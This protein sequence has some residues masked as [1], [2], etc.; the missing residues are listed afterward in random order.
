MIYSKDNGELVLDVDPR[1]FTEESLHDLWKHNEE[2]MFKVFMETLVHNYGNW[3]G[4]IPDDPAAISF[5]VK[6]GI[7]NFE[8]DRKLIDL[9]KIMWYIMCMMR[10][11]DHNGREDTTAKNTFA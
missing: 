5:M 8:K 4:E 7:K 10:Y 11:C 1:A 6:R 2:L 9:V 3:I